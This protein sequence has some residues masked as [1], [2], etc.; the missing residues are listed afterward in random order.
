MADAT[1]DT[2]EMDQQ[3]TVDKGS[4]AAIPIHFRPG[5]GKEKRFK[6]V[7]PGIDP[8]LAYFTVRGAKPE[9]ISIVEDSAPEDTVVAEDTSQ[10]V[11]ETEGGEVEQVDDPTAGQSQSLDEAEA[12]EDEDT[13]KVNSPDEAPADEETE[14]EQTDEQYPHED[15]ANNPVAGFLIASEDGVEPPVVVVHPKEGESVT[16]AMTRV[17]AD[18]P[19]HQIA[20]LEDAT[21]L[22]GHSPLTSKDNPPILVD[23]NKPGNPGAPV[24]WLLK[25]K[26]RIAI[27]TDDDESA[28]DAISRVQAKHPGY[29]LIKGA[30][31]PSS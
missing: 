7:I 1:E 8:P 14:T 11:D 4:Y 9:T 15:A 6:L 18:H 17:G 20:N 26:D 25:G 24:A 5:E 16:A 3:G 12:A 2:F 30:K 29:K 28:D 10:D 21:K 23:I 13:E 27:I 31:E 19:D 22:L